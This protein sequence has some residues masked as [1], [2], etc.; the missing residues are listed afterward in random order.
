MI[1]FHAEINLEKGMVDSPLHI[2]NTVIIGV[3]SEN[4]KVSTLLLG[5]LPLM[6]WICNRIND[7]LR[8]LTMV[9]YTKKL[10][11]I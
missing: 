8:F 6:L 5:Q 7:S 9:D 11:I 4:K 3:I 2:R 10:D 1:S